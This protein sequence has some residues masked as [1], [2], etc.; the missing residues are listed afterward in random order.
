LPIPP[1]GPVLFLADHPVTGGC[2]VIGVIDPDD[3][4]LAAQAPP[5]T[6]V[7]VRRAN[8]D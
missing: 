2:P 1:S 8:P 4:W 6:T 5:G 7:H 3:L